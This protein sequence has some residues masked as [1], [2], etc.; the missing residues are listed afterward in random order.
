[1]DLKKKTH[2]HKLTQQNR[3]S[4]S[5][6]KKTDNKRKLVATVLACSTHTRTKIERKIH[7][8]WFTLSHIVL[9]FHGSNVGSF[10]GSFIRLYAYSFV[11]SFALRCL[12]VSVPLMSNTTYTIIFRRWIS[13]CLHGALAHTHPYVYAIGRERAL[14]THAL[15]GSSCIWSAVNRWKRVFVAAPCVCVCVLR[16]LLY[17]VH[18]R[19]A[20]SRSH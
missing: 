13:E 12:L 2:E 8:V 9:M 17:C 10:N 5:K 6:P 3:L 19:L 15:F 7:S 20:H 11:R 18:E 4:K 14:K 1:M 16:L